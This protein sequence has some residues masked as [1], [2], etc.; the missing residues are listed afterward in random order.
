[1][2][3]SGFTAEN[4]LDARHGQ[5][6]VA[7]AQQAAGNVVLPAQLYRYCEGWPPVCCTCDLTNGD[8]IAPGDTTLCES[9]SRCPESEVR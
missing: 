6:L 3:M 2:K 7:A 5:Y 8:V 9:F 4:S 1:M